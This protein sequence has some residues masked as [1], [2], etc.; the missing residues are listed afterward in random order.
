MVTG[1]VTNCAVAMVLLLT[2]VLPES[3]TSLSTATEL[4]TKTVPCM[5]RGSLTRL[6]VMVCVA[7]WAKPSL[8]VSVSE[9]SKLPA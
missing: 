4:D 6:V 5:T 7:V 3:L 2:G 8:L 9:I 1:L